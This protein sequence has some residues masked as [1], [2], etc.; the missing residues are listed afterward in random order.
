MTPS[1]EEQMMES[2]SYWQLE[3]VIAHIIVAKWF[4]GPEE[5][6]RIVELR[7]A[8]RPTTTTKENSKERLCF[9]E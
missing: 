7:E 2:A 3:K 9:G 1:Y 5:L 8:M 6:R 4:E